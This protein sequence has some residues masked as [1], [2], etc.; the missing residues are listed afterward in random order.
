M[1]LVTNMDERICANKMPESQKSSIC[2]LELE[3]CQEAT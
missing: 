2:L 1:Y 3:G